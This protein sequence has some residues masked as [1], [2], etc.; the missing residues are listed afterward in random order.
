MNQVSYRKDGLSIF[1]YT[2]AKTTALKMGQK[3]ANPGGDNP[4]GNDMRIHNN[5]AN[6]TSKS[7]CYCCWLLLLPLM[8]MLPVIQVAQNMR[9]KGSQVPKKL[10]N[11]SRL[12]FTNNATKKKSTTIT[13]PMKTAAVVK[14]S[15]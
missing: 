12:L 10:R 14:G 8:T 5:L 6:M 15:V 1:G 2:S 9:I 4:S 11:I 3:A 7:Y 13:N